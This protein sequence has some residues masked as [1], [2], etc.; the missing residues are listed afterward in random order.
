[1]RVIPDLRQQTRRL[2][3]GLQPNGNHPDRVRESTPG[4]VNPLVH[5]TSRERYISSIKKFNLGVNKVNPVF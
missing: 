1:M 4:V 5:G 3:P 2:F